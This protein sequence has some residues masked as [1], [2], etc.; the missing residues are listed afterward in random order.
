MMLL[1]S[2][3]CV[4]LAYNEEDVIARS[5]ARVQ[6]VA[7]RVAV[8]HEVIVVGYEGA[9]D[10]TLAIVGALA[11]TDPRIRLVVQPR[12][13]KGYGRAMVLGLRESR[14]EWVFQS[15]ADGQYDFGDLE[16]LVALASPPGVVLVHGHRAPRRDS[17]ERLLFAWLYNRALRAIYR[18][19][20]RDV[21]SAFKLIRGDVARGVPIHSQTGFAVSEL[22]MRVYN[23]RGASGGRIVEVAVT[24]LAR[25]TGEALSDKGIRNPFGLELPNLRL[26]R[27]TL[28][29]MVR[30]R[31]QLLAKDGR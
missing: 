9:R 7:A 31:G 25:Q 4:L 26:V 28:A 3:S 20:V 2:L 22:I 29:E 5:I 11:A 15:D 10:R 8:E 18:I 6:E 30:M 21:D 14:M 17:P 23:R 19:P 12:A 24:H 13:A 1:R 27:E 16:K